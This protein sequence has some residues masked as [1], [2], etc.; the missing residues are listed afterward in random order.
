MSWASLARFKSFKAL[1]NKRLK[2][3]APSWY[4]SLLFVETSSSRRS[5]G[6]PLGGPT[7]IRMLRSMLIV[8]AACLFAAAPRSS[9]ASR[10]TPRVS[11]SGF[12][13]VSGGRIYYEAFGSGPTVILLHG[14][15][16]DRRMWD[17]QL[18]VLTAHF[19]VIRFD[20]RGF[21]RSSPADTAYSGAEDL[22]V[23]MRQ[24]GV[25]HTVLVG[26]SLGGRTVIDFTLAHPD[27]VQKLVVAGPG[28]S[29]WTDWSR[30]DTTWRA[31]ARHAGYANDSVGMAMSWL[32]ADYMRAAMERPELAKRLRVL[33]ADNAAY[34]M[35]LFRHGDLERVADSPAITRLSQIRTPTL[36]VVGDRDSP[37]ICKIVDTLAARLP[38]A[39]VVRVP[40][41]GHM[42]NMEQPA[43]FDRAV[44]AFLLK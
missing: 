22:Y 15:L 24:L 18:P 37:V 36:V 43:A 29:G 42:V 7:A 9:R 11:D 31:E 8:A 20:A 28:L 25:Q 41:A 40:N 10:Q 13:S 1:P 34:W 3:A 32:T 27:M 26:L 35:G 16:L 21:G 17:Q 2:L 5:L 6:H 23:L 33:A 19:R 12:V 39:T 14:A 44:V 4:G 30:E 38:R